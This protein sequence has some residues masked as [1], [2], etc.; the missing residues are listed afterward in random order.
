MNV[1]ECVL[2]GRYNTRLGISLWYH[3]VGTRY[4]ISFLSRSVSA[5]IHCWHIIHYYCIHSNGTTCYT[6]R[7]ER[8]ESCVHVADGPNETKRNESKRT[9]CVAR[10]IAEQGQQTHSCAQ[11]SLWFRILQM[12][13]PQPYPPSPQK[14]LQLRS[15]TTVIDLGEHAQTFT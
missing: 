4:R 5:S 11:S 12:P 14:P 3:V 9:G 7:I 8:V 15:G 1:C 6:I 13:S 10:R 2:G